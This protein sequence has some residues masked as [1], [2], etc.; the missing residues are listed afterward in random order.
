MCVCPE[1]TLWVVLGTAS[2]STEDGEWA[3]GRKYTEELGVQ[4][5]S[6]KRAV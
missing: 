4:V 2:Q 5:L 1:G 6:L 3:R